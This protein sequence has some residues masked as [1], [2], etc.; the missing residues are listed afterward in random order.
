M[1]IKDNDFRCFTLH[2]YFKIEG[3]ELFNNE[4]GYSTITVS[5]ATKKIDEITTIAGYLEKGN[6]LKVAIANQCDVSVDNI[7]LI[8][9]EEYHE[10]T[11]DGDIEI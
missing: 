7:T 6:M 4:V 1:N 11:D 5:E 3:S 8:S 2:F 10:N 9:R